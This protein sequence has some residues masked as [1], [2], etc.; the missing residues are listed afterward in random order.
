MSHQHY[1]HC[2][3]I[4][5]LHN[6]S[7]SENAQVENRVTNRGTTPVFIRRSQICVG[8]SHS[9]S[10]R[11]CM[12]IVLYCFINSTNLLV[13]VSPIDKS[14]SCH[15]INAENLVVARYSVC[16][17][18][19]WLNTNYKQVGIIRE[20]NQQ[21]DKMDYSADILVALIAFFLAFHSS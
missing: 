6:E 7:I 9:W 18:S 4:S 19:L 3:W 13:S 10:D 5:Q 8:L 17:I 20:E 15:R 11:D 21:C 14:I 16:T 12:Y 2:N 1:I